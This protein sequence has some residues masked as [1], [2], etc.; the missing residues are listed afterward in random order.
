MDKFLELNDG[1]ELKTESP[2]LKDLFS[3]L[4]HMYHST[5]WHLL[6]L[7]EGITY[8]LDALHGEALGL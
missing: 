8:I 4:Q 2:D 3:I 7:T 1:H 5:I 6:L